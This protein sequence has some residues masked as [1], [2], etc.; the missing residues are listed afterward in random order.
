MKNVKQ[1]KLIEKVIMSRIQNS[2]P[3]YQTRN[4]KAD[5]LE[6]KEEESKQYE[7]Q[8][9]NQLNDDMLY[10]MLLVQDIEKRVSKMEKSIEKIANHMEKTDDIL[11]KVEK[12]LKKQ[13]NEIDRVYQKVSKQ[14]AELKK[15]QS[16]A[17]QLEKIIRCIGVGLGINNMS[18]NVDKILKKCSDNIGT[19]RIQRKSKKGIIDTSAT[20]SDSEKGNEL[21]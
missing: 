10:F 3:Q 18:D 15:E 17:K 11:E 21:L 4:I 12:K 14:K 9:Y 16:Q 19:Y 7:Q 6:Q 8:N 20:I 13:S 5:F 1:N 2:I